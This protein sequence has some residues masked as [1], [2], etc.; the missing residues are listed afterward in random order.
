MSGARLAVLDG[1]RGVSI[2][3]VL[4]GH[5]FPVGPKAW[6]L[7]EA[8]AGAG[9]AI[10]FILSGFLITSL[11]LK[12]DRIGAF[13]VRRLLRIVPLAWLAMVLSLAAQGEWNLLTAARHLTFTANWQPIALTEGTSHLWSLCVEMQFYMGMAMA[14]LVLRRQAFVLLPLM[15][16]AVTLLRVLNHKYMVIDTQFRVDEILAGCCLALAF[17][18]RPALLAGGL[19]RLPAWSMLALLIF[20]AHSAS[21]WLNYLRPYLAMVMVGASLLAPASAWQTR[22]L[23]SKVLA[24]LATVSYAL[25]VIHGGLRWTWLGTG[26]TLVKYLKRPLLLAATFVLAHISTFHFERHFN[27]LA[28]NW[29][30]RDNREPM[31]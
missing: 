4:W 19:S 31:A 16:L 9:M 25:Y 11:L 21:Q 5:L 24:Y 17:H 7:N 29:A 14:V 10:F 15:T 27:E 8:V 26:D 22:V 12:D 18:K 3:L 6:R 1:W 20:S 2:A 23:S 28:R 30:S 13:L